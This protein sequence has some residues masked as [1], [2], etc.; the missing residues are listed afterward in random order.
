M[1]AR[2]ERI[3]TAG[4]TGTGTGLRARAIRVANPSDPDRPI[5]A[6][7]SVD[8]APG[9]TLVIVGE[10][11]AGKSML[12][13]AICG[14]APAQ[15]TTSGTVELAGRTIDLGVAAD[16]LR[17]LRGGGIV[18]L[19]QDPFTSLSPLHRCGVQVIAHRQGPRSE[20]AER[21]LARLAEVGFPARAARA[22]P[23]QLSGGMRQRVA[24]AAALDAAPGVLIADEPT[25]ALD[26]TTQK[27]ILTL[28]ASLR[29]A[30]GMALVLV[31]HDLA[32][33]R[34]YGDDIVVMRG[35]AIVEA[36]QARRV[37]ARPATD[38]ARQLL[39][40]Q[41]RLDGPSPRPAGAVPATTVADERPIVA[42]RDVVKEF[43][44]G[45]RRAEGHL[46]LA[47]VSLDILPGQSVGIVG[48]S[49]SGK[50]TLAR[51]MV[52]LEAPDS[53]TV[54]VARAPGAG[55]GAPPPVG[56]VFQNPYSALNPART[57]GQTL[58]E[59]LA[60]GGQGG[61][62]VPDLLGAVGL[63]AAH[64]QR[65]PAALSG[66]QRQRVAIARALAARP[67]L[68]ICDEAVSALDVSVQATII[69][70]LRR[71][72]AEQGFAL[73]FITHDLAVARQMSD[74]IIV[75]KDGAIVEEGATEA[76]LAAP[77]HPYT[78]SLIDAVPGRGA[79]A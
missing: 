32:L 1:T 61:A 14:L 37:L 71:L 77:S 63:P 45:G 64:A 40:A 31:T 16:S 7:V 23:H 36:G 70:L 17:R 19:P 58:A 6:D 62:Q 55:R 50:T 30:R 48:E 20:R 44:S 24:I 60:V 18:W 35:G 12:A 38:Y 34:D 47:G 52:G 15:F 74:R 79:P 26:V 29:D 66:G 39:D 13:R 67:E 21:A 49:G 27:E 5:V 57:V 33:A 3:G 4:S 69:D 68:L 10:S 25:T 72:Q 65:L 46:A 53:G 76:L 11:G 54:H 8:A 75:M 28:L 78:A 43:R 73:A 22:Y 42:L 41:L 9:R 51:I 2:A 59:A 56:I